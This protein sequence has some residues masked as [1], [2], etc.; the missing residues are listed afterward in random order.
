MSGSG[1]NNQMNGKQNGE[2][3]NAIHLRVDRLSPHTQLDDELTVSNNWTEYYNYYGTYYA[4]PQKQ[5]QH[6]PSTSIHLL[7]L[8][9]WHAN[10]MPIA[11]TP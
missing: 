4:M 3:H 7:S 11:T 8:L 6:Q 5:Q 1:L 10:D 2:Q 9:Q